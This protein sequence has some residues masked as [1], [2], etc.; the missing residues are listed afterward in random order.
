M[1]RKIDGV[2][3]SKSIMLN[4]IT[5]VISI[6][7]SLISTIVITRIIS[8]SDLGI[9]TSF[10]TLKNILNL[11]CLLSIYISINRI[12]LDIKG[13]DYEYLSSIYIFSSLFCIITFV[14]YL[15]FHHYLNVIF[16]FN[17]KMMSL[18]FIMIFL[19]NGCNLMINYCNFKNKYI[20]MFIYNLLASPV[21]QI[22]S[23]VFASVLSSH[24]YLGR[25]IGVDLFNI[26][27][28]LGCGIFILSKGRFTFKKKYVIDS[29]KICIPMIPH[30]LAQIL[31]S[32]CDLL[33]IKNIINNNAAGIYSMAYTIS[34]I[35]YTIL[36]QL[37]MPWSPW[38]YRRIKNNEIDSI[39]K[40]SKTLIIGA[41]FLCVSLFTVAPEMIHIFLNKQYFEA[42]FIVA[43]I[44]VGI[45]FQIMYIFFY[46]I[47]YYHKKNKQIAFFSVL[48]SI[49]NIVLNF[50]FI[51]QFGYIAAAYTTLI[52]YLV[53]LILHYIGMRIVDKRDFYDIKTLFITSILLFI[54]AIIYVLTNNNFILRYC[55]LIVITIVVIIKYYKN[56]KQ[57][58][59]I[60]IKK[61]V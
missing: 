58:I 36:V 5:S 34:N 47:E 23:L 53:L 40:N 51:K 39:K 42:S 54:I 50:I 27:L 30:L 38:V 59:D 60:F 29:L 35:L 20:V 11:I 43:P 57:I 26:V 9:A 6:V 33:M 31:L 52:S 16:G 10:I 13:K 32:S 22:L 49:I 3:T 4:A 1:N 12:I 14:I 37:F 24:K 55:M 48:T 25:I 46:D 44:T 28:G 17:T 21:A 19:I 2:K 41:W 61:G 8:V 15:I 18:M 7:V 45:Y 56:I